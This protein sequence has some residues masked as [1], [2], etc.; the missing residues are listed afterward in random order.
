MQNKRWEQTM[1]VT[2]LLFLFGHSL[3][4]YVFFL[5][6][7]FNNNKTLLH[8]NLYGEAWIEF[9]VIPVTMCFGIWSI[10]QVARIMKRE[11]HDRICESN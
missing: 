9:I 4:L 6:A 5:Q 7:F 3:S 10:I 1:I 2:G 11:K 8:I